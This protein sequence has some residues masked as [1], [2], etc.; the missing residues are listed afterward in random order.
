MLAPPDFQMH[1]TRNAR[2]FCHLDLRDSRLPDHISGAVSWR[3]YERLKSD[4]KLVERWYDDALSELTPRLV[5]RLIKRPYRDDPGTWLKRVGD[6]ASVR[7]DMQEKVARFLPSRPVKDRRLERDPL[8]T[9]YIARKL[10]NAA[11]GHILEERGGGY[12]RDPDHVQ[13]PGEWISEPQSASIR[14]G[15]DLVNQAARLYP[16]VEICD[17]ARSQILAMVGSEGHFGWLLKALTAANREMLDWAGGPFPHSK[18][19]GPAT[20]ESSSVMASPQLR[21]M[22][23]FTIRTGES[24][25][26]EHHMKHVGLNMRMHYRVDQVRRRLV[27]GYVGRHLPTTLY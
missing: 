2:Q 23:C 13:G 16:A 9:D 6:D 17:G 26:F 14:S 20:G 21:R 11:A 4:G 24:L 25:L 19:P 27:V 7:T 8:C 15:W 10:V 22:R 1:E 3:E 12:V 5:S 18:L